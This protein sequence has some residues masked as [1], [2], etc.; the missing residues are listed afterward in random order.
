MVRD[1]EADDYSDDCNCDKFIATNTILKGWQHGDQESC[2]T[3][4]QLKPGS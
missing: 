3:F 1:I 4:D 2:D